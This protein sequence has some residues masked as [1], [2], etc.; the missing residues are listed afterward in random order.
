MSKHAE[1]LRLRLAAGPQTG[2]QMAKQMGIS[3]PTATRALAAMGDEVMKLGE[4]KSSRY[5]LRDASRGFGDVPVFRVDG[6]GRL[7]EMGVLTPVRPDGFVFTQADGTQAHCDSLPW[8][9]LDMRPQG[10]LGRTYAARY[11]GNLG[12][13]HT[14]KE[15]TDNHSMR[16]LLIHGHNLVGNLLLGHTAREQ[17]MSAP[18]PTCIPHAAKPSEYARLAQ[19]AA[20]GELPGSSA[21][22]EQ[23]KFTTYA[24]TDAGPA[25]VLVKFTEKLNSPVSQRWRD[26]LMAE[27]LALTTLRDS[28]V[29]AARSAVVDH[30]GQ[31]FLEVVRFDRVGT[32]G[33]QALMSLTALDAE[34]VGAAHQPWPIITQ[35][36]ALQG[37]VTPETAEAVEL[38]WAFGTLIGNTDMHGGNVSFMSEQGRPFIAAP[39]YDMTPMTFAPSSSGKLSNTIPKTAFHACVR[40]HHWRSALGL[41]QRYVK[42][43]QSSPAFS[44]DFAECVDALIDHVE[45]AQTQIAR[46]A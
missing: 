23:P 16:A 5:V 28:G 4:K 31:R 35:Q 40:N 3:Q 45:R 36:L 41:A 19:E 12:L 37:I 25:H 22:G 21:G 11:G 33:R 46:L 30:Q 38:L 29:A 44:A 10:Y 14:L 17:F 6:Q 1:H 42:A 8:W 26:L 18:E 7:E 39:A 24:E 27:H 20:H 2:T 34:F 13:P 9:L 43:L 15:W 32:L